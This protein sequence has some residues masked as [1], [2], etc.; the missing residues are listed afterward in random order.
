[1]KVVRGDVV[2][3]DFPFASGVGQK[4]RPA[5]VVR[6][7]TYNQKL[8][9]TILAPIT[10]NT[11][12]SGELTQVLIEPKSQDDAASGLLK[13]SAVKCENLA[14]VENVLIRRK[15]GILSPRLQFAVDQALKAALAVQ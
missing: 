8:D 2:L 14:T 7:D 9:S 6:A 13:S 11:R 5:V 1:M 15:I 10:S 3:V 4:L 12:Y